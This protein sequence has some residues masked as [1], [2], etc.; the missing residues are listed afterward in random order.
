MVTDGHSTSFGT[1]PG[2]P[3][4]W[5]LTAPHRRFRPPFGEVAFTL[6]QS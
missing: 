5:V 2:V 4:L 6:D 3:V 1:D